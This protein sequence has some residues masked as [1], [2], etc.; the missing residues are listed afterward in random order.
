MQS[1][2]P[3]TSA[4]SPSDGEKEKIAA[5]F[6]RSFNSELPSR[7]E[8]CSLAPSDGERVRVRGFLH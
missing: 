7:D 4:L 8:M 2:I 5:S 6:E 1:D 3:R